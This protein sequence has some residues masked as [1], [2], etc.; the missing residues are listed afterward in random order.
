[1][2]SLV[3]PPALPPPRRSTRSGCPGWFPSLAPR[4]PPPRRSTRSGCP[5]WE[6]PRVGTHRHRRCSE[7]GTRPVPEGL[8]CWGGARVVPRRKQLAPFARGFESGFPRHLAL[9]CLGL[10]HITHYYRYRQRKK[11]RLAPVHNTARAGFHAARV[12]GDV[13]AL[14]YIITTAHIPPC[15]LCTSLAQKPLAPP[16]RRQCSQQLRSAVLAPPPLRRQCPQQLRSA[17]LAPPPL[18]RQC[19]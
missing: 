14:F 10:D 1:L 17:V 8:R 12:A 11:A 13:R 18:R 3:S 4:P 19:S 6:A 7:W 5:Q 2:V 9:S 15:N 16:L